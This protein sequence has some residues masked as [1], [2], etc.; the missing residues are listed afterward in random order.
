MEAKKLLTGM[1]LKQHDR[2]LKGGCYNCDMA[3]MKRV[4]HRKTAPERTTVPFHKVFMDLDFID[5]PTLEKHSVYLHLIDEGSR[6]QWLYLQQ[7]KEETVDRLRDFR[8]HVKA[9]HHKDVRIFH[10]DQGPEF[11]NTKVA[12]Q[13]RGESLQIFSH[14]HTPEEACLIDKA[15][16]T[17]FNK[18]RAVLY[19]SACCGVWPPR[20]WLRQ[21]TAQARKATRAT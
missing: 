12:E 6:Y 7:N 18:V 20:T 4:S 9:K 21:S 17:L 13:L 16:S 10:S 3:K 2:K 15:R 19:S 8:D 11:V 1:R 14:P 5:V